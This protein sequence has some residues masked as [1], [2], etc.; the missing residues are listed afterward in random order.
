M[1]TWPDA[2]FAV[3]RTASSLPFIPQR[4]Y[5]DR[6]LSKVTFPFLLRVTNL[7]PLGS[8]RRETRVMFA[9]MYRKHLGTLSY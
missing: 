6:P 4:L 7:R 9:R 3:D 1:D 2:G 5:N 8:D